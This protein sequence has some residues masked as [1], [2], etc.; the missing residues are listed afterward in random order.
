MQQQELTCNSSTTKDHDNAKHPLYNLLGATSAQ[1][2]QYNVSIAP[3][4]Q[5]PGTD[6][7]LV[8]EMPRSTFSHHKEK[9]GTLNVKVQFW[10]ISN[11]VLQES[12]CI[13]CMPLLQ[14]M[15]LKAVI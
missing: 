12:P 1:S 10:K 11:A 15:G 13:S 6:C 14:P 3:S 8:V 5:F 2:P 9:Q 4:V 7:V